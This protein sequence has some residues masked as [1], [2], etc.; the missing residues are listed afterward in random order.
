M[1]C[2]RRRRVNEMKK[3][4][5]RHMH[6]E[7]YAVASYQHGMEGG[8]FQ[9]EGGRGGGGNSETKKEHHFCPGPRV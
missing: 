7:V 3:T 2:K 9:D 6:V 5:T 8:C 1:P 4:H